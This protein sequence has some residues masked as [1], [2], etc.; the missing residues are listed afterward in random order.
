MAEITYEIKRHYGVLSTSPA[1]WTHEVNLISWNG[2]K[3]KLDIRSWSPDK[4]KM[5]KGST[6]TYEEAVGLFNTLA[7]IIAENSAKEEA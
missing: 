1:G 3:P 6:M 5:S 7:D 2:A 4:A